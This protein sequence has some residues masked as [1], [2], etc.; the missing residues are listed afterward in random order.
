VSA[1]RTE[2]RLALMLVV[3]SALSTRVAAAADP[4]EWAAPTLVFE[5]AGELRES[6]LAVDPAGT[7][8]VAWSVHLGHDPQ[9]QQVHMARWDGAAWVEPS[10]AINAPTADAPSLAIDPFADIHLVWHGA[11][12]HVEYTWTRVAYDTTGWPPSTDLGDADIRS[13]LRADPAGVLHLAVPGS[14][15][16]G[17]T[18]RRSDDGG[19]T[20]TRPVQVA[21]PS[22]PG[23]TTDYARLAVSDGGVL[24]LVWSEFEAKPRK[25]PLGVYYARSTD[26]GRSWSA[27][28][29]L[30]GPG[31]GQGN[32][33]AVGDH[34]VHVAWN[35]AQDIAGRYHRW[36][37]D[38][39]A[40]WSPAQTVVAQGVNEGPPQLVVD[41]AQT[42][43]LVT[44]YDAAAWV[45]SWNG[46]GWSAPQCIS[47]G[48]SPPPTVVDLP[49]AIVAN[50]DELHVLYDQ[51]RRRL[52][53][54]T[55]HLAAPHRSPSA[56]Q[57]AGWLS[58]RVRRRELAGIPALLGMV[59]S[60]V[61][62]RWLRVRRTPAA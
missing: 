19:V 57:T 38:D 30:A 9:Q 28:T 2:R 50:G 12:Q 46:A 31:F 41:A 25:L 58:E 7:V 17:P 14:R 26:G 40:T 59:A 62:V 45:A 15:T 3:A 52:W 1:L 42:L 55:A 56:P 23:A 37:S 20:W 43:Y 48:A 21:V 60:V 6:A 11:M 22:R 10:R 8:Y 29:Q 4:G 61:L 18:Y 44:T 13:Q 54:T 32:V 51:D 16:A 33:V 39:G 36:S 27:P 47:C 53:H 5:S 24:H 34:A 49:S 35:G